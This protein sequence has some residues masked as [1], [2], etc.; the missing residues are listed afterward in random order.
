M[1]Y[2]VTMDAKLLTV[3]PLVTADSLTTAVEASAWI[4]DLL[5]A[6]VN[7]HP[8]DDFSDYVLTNALGVSQG[9]AFAPAEA[10]RLN[11]ALERAHELFQAAGDDIYEAARAWHEAT[12]PRPAAGAPRA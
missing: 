7:F 4:R 1:A 9:A 5:A 11:L 2:N 8:D 3:T 12:P 6:G 10:H